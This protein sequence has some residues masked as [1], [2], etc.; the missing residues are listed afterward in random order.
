MM[1]TL[2]L[3][4]VVQSDEE[5]PVVGWETLAKADPSVIVIAKMDRRR[6]EA[7]DYEK[8]IAFLKSDP[9]ASQMTAVKENRIVVMDAHT[10][11][12]SIRSVSGLEQLGQALQAFGLAQ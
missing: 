1:E 7:D 10:M 5:W 11:D 3:R 6:F 4:N 9:V 8:K 12:P 2:G